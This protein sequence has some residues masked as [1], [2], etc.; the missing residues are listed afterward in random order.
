M[1]ILLIQI[2]LKQADDS[3]WVFRQKKN[4]AISCRGRVKSQ[5]VSSSFFFRMFAVKVVAAELELREQM[6]KVSP[7]ESPKF[8]HKQKR[9]PHSHRTGKGR[10]SKPIF[11][12]ANQGD[13]FLAILS[14]S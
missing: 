2:K 7:G 10:D 8:F 6:V 1:F 13:M 3:S 14:H 11:L 4:T 5:W 12:P 9:D